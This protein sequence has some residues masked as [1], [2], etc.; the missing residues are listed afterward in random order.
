MNLI[1][2]NEAAP[3]P[4]VNSQKTENL[5]KNLEIIKFENKLGITENNYLSG[6][7]FEPVSPR[8]TL[9]QRAN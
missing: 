8:L 3:Q 5:K 7:G 4:Q 6:R 9:S 1:P 2:Q